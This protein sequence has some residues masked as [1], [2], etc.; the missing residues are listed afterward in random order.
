MVFVED[1][2]VRVG[3]VCAAVAALSVAGSLTAI[4]LKLVGHATP[5]WFS[6]SLGIL[7]L[8]FLQT[9]TITLMTLMLTGIVRG[10]IV[11]EVDYNDLVDGIVAA[12]GG[13]GPA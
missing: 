11:N 7:F 6:I 2:L 5:G 1:V 12:D 3:I 10:N 8:V 4:G 9:G 13:G